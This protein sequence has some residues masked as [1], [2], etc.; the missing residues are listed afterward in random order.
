MRLD[1]RLK[2]LADRRNK[3]HRSSMPATIQVVYFE[4]NERTGKTI[5]TDAVTGEVIDG[6]GLNPVAVV[7]ERMWKSLMVGD[8]DGTN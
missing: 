7:S 1:A 3:M 8:D 6:K 4:T 2:R 5:Y